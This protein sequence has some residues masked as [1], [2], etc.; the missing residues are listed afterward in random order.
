MILSYQTPEP[1]QIRII[2]RAEWSLIK[3][4]VKKKGY[5]VARSGLQRSPAH[6][7]TPS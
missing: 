4:R 6:F 3:G 1:G 5:P 2:V 7:I